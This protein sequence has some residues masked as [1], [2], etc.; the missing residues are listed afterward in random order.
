MPSNLTGF[1]GTRIMFQ[2]C[3]GISCYFI[4][5][6]PIS[7]DRKITTSGLLLLISDYT[8]ML[9]AF[10]IFKAL[11]GYKACYGYFRLVVCYKSVY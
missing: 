6:H 3:N 1:P 11:L 2:A 7:P 10:H 8:F 5:Q 4:F 9:K